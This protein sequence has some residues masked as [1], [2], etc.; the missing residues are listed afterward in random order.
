MMKRKK[1]ALCIQSNA[2]ECLAHITAAHIQKEAG[3]EKA[4]DLFYDMLEEKD[5]DPQA[6]FSQIDGLLCN[7]REMWEQIKTRI[8]AQWRFVFLEELV[9]QGIDS[10][11]LQI[12]LESGMEA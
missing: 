8:P 10:C 3:N 12:I 11:A 6:V 7:E 1:S 4:L 2:V 9:E 5:I